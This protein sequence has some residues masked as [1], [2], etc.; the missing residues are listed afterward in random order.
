MARQMAFQVPRRVTIGKLTDTTG[1]APLEKFKNLA[2]SV[3]AVRQ[4]D[5]RFGHRSAKIYT[6]KPVDNLRRVIK[7]RVKCFS[8]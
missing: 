6:E 2:G 8:D 5:Q 4:R 7:L 1:L 3:I